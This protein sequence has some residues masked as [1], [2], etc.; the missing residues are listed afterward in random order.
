MCMVHVLFDKAMCA[1]HRN[2]IMQLPLNSLALA[3]TVFRLVTVNLL[4]GFD[5]QHQVPAHGLRETLHGAHGWEFAAFQSRH[6]AL[7]CAHALRNFT[8]RHSGAG[9]G[10]NQFAGKGVF[11][12]HRFIFGACFGIG[13]QFA[14]QDFHLILSVVIYAL[15]ISNQ[16]H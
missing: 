11:I 7:R 15:T 12:G 2:L 1:S 4:C 13:Q 16:P 3:Q 10:G 14:F 5:A 6:Y 8:L 9:A